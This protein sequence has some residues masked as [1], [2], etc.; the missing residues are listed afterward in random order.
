[1]VVVGILVDAGVAD[2]AQDDRM[3]VPANITTRDFVDTSPPSGAQT[4]AVE[5][6]SNM[7]VGP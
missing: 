1:M 2:V 5:F 4:N 3:K 7:I 6:Y